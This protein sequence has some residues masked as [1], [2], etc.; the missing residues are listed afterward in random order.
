[1]YLLT[2]INVKGGFARFSEKLIGKGSGSVAS[3]QFFWIIGSTGD[4]LGPARVAKQ[5]QHK[6]KGA[7]IAGSP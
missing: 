7:A 1:M 2:I 3:G 5:L 4:V 6:E